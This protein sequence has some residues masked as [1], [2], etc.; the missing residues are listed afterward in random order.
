LLGFWISGTNAFAKLVYIWILVF[1]RVSEFNDRRGALLL[2]LPFPC[3][4]GTSP[5]T[6]GGTA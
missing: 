1:G 4:V 2:S 6:P 3:G 5:M